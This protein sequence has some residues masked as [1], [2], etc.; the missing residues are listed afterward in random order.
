MKIEIQNQEIFLNKNKE[1]AFA[2]FSSN[3]ACNENLKSTTRK[4][5]LSF[6]ENKVKAVLDVI[7]HYVFRNTDNLY[8]SGMDFKF[9]KAFRKVFKI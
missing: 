9:E 7:K 2:E 6:K 1:L 4:N 3:F 8:D 5:Y